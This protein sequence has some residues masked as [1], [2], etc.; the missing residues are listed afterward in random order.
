MRS[1]QLIRANASSTRCGGLLPIQFFF[2]PSVF[3]VPPP[4]TV[5][6]SRPRTVNVNMI[7]ITDGHIVKSS[8]FATPRELVEVEKWVQPL[9]IEKACWDAFCHRGRRM[10]WPSSPMSYGLHEDEL[11][12][13]LFGTAKACERPP[14]R[15]T[16]CYCC[17]LQPAETRLV[18]DTE[19]G[20][21]LNEVRFWPRSLLRSELKK[22]VFSVDL[23]R[24][25]LPSSF[26]RSPCG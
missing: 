12:I 11:G 22:N 26:W 7:H 9:E 15:P 20:S 21:S 24:A 13:I 25:Y 6:P 5:S 18:L 3:I 19:R 8:G 4:P 17:A 1:H 2:R 10:Q 14:P 23:E 16:T